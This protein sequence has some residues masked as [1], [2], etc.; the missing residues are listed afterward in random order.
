MIEKTLFTINKPLVKG[1]IFGNENSQRVIVFSHGFGVKRDSRGMFSELAELL[2]NNFLLVLFDYVSI[3]GQNNTTV[4]SL[5]TQ[6]KMLDAVIDYMNKNYD[7]KEVNLLAHSLGCEIAGISSPPNLNTV[8]LVAP[9]TAPPAESIK[10]H[11]KKR[12]GTKINESAVSVIRRS[13]GTLT[14]IPADFWIDAKIVNPLDKYLEL[15]KKSKRFYVV[16]AKHDQVL[17]EEDYSV[18]RSSPKIDFIDIDGNHDFD[19]KFRKGW[20]NSMEKLFKKN[21]EK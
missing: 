14:Y 11:F 19:N 21:L 1:E 17:A 5:T 8:V 10:E 15:S 9:P 2:K 12:A 18:L 13:D 4:P 6:S 20:L 7:L 3:D 16:R